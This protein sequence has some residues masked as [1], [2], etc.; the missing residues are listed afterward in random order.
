MSAPVSPTPPSLW[1]RL[2]QELEK[3]SL[4]EMCLRDQPESCKKGEASKEAC[5]K[6][7]DDCIFWHILVYNLTR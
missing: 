2:K 7:F 3:D 1:T 5:K 4:R 6:V